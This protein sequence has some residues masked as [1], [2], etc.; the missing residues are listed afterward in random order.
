MLVEGMLISKDVHVWPV[1]FLHSQRTPY[2]IDR[3]S[4]WSSSLV[5]WCLT[6]FAWPGVCSVLRGQPNAFMPTTMHSTHAYHAH[7]LKIRTPTHR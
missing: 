3:L 1:V 6:I 4:P 5:L 7:L 2:H